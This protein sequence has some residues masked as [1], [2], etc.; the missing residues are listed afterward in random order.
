MNHLFAYGSL[1]CTDIMRDVSGCDLSHSD[2][3]LRGHRRRVVIGE[4]YPG[5]V[6]GEDGRVDGVVY[7]AVP[8]SAWDRL[9]RFEGGMYVRQRLEILLEDGGDCAGGR[10]RCAPGA[11]GSP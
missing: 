8:S 11:P 1:M 9:G 2:G 7:W 6:P 5:L 3:I 4:Q 10:L